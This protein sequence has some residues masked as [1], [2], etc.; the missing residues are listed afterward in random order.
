LGEPKLENSTCS[1]LLELERK[2]ME[3]EGEELWK[4]EGSKIPG[5]HSQRN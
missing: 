1:L 5:D 4:P 3:A 2:P